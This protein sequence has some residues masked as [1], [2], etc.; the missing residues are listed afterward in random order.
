MLKD[1]KVSRHDIPP[2]ISFPAIE[3]NRICAI[4]ISVCVCLI[5]FRPLLSQPYPP[6]YPSPCVSRIFLQQQPSALQKGVVFVSFFSNSLPHCKIKVI[7]QPS[8]PRQSKNGVLGAAKKKSSPLATVGAAFTSL[9]ADEA[10]A[11]CSQAGFEASFVFPLSYDDLLGR[12][13]V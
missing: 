8:R 2:P 11:E 12:S 10:A 1:G 3:Q 13:L 4:A 7:R 9:L 6:P 5:P